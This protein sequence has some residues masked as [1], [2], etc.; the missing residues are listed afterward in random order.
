TTGP[1]LG[2]SEVI[3]SSQLPTTLT[4]IEFNFSTPVVLEADTTYYLRL[5]SIPDSTVAGSGASGYIAWGYRQNATSPYPGG[6]AYRYIGSQNNP[7]GELLDQFDFSF[8]VYEINVLEH[9]WNISISSGGFAWTLY[10]EAYTTKTPAPDNFTFYYSKDGIN[11]VEMVTVTATSDTNTYL[12]YKFPEGSLADISPLAPLRIKVKDT[13]RTVDDNASIELDLLHIDHMYVETKI[14]SSRNLSFDYIW[15]DVIAS[16]TATYSI[17]QDIE[18]S[19]IDKNGR[20]DIVAGD[21]DGTTLIYFNNVADPLNR[22]VL[23]ESW[24]ERAINKRTAVKGVVHRIELGYF[25]GTGDNDLDIVGIYDD[26]LYTSRLTG[27]D[28]TYPASWTNY[29]YTNIVDRELSALAVGDMNNDGLMD[30]EIG[31]VMETARDRPQLW[32]I[33]QSAT[34]IPATLTEGVD[35]IRI[36]TVSMNEQISQRIFNAVKPPQISD[37]CIGDLDGDGDNDTAI[38][39]SLRGQWW[40]SDIVNNLWA[41]FN[42]RTATISNIDPDGSGISGPTTVLWYEEVQIYVN[43]WDQTAQETIYNL[44][45]GYID[46]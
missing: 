38:G 17:I 26:D 29:N 40:Q 32:Q 19:D 12:T 8:N 45:L 1:V 21:K 4:W 25:E 23:P 14:Y 16:T 15:V 18:M 6:V 44:E 3:Q 30:I 39:L 2:S 43:P 37:I 22:S 10:L 11:W 7:E 9:V 35:L 24:K 27:T 28:A 41:Y 33:R 42:N 31:T 46:R 20:T 13:N 34:G 5:R 36:R